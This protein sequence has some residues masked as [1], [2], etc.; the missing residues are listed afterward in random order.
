VIKAAKDKILAPGAEIDEQV[1]LPLSAAQREV[2]FAQQVDPINSAYNI[3][4]YIEIHGPVNVA[5]F[6]QAMRQ[7]L[8]EATSMRASFYVNLDENGPRQIIHPLDRA[9][10][11]IDLSAEID[12][13][14]ALRRATA[15]FERRFR[16]VELL[17]AEH[18]IGADLDA[19]DALWQQVK[20]DE[21]ES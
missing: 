7:V 10:S 3:A 17:A 5:L 13:E 11:F 20:R 14:E 8:Q 6:N 1:D 9:M 2:W 18:G 21:C 12:P 16:R 15:K 19:L 4:D